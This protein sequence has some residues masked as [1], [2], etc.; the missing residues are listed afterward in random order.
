MV[1]RSGRVARMLEGD[2]I[3]EEEILRAAVFDSEAA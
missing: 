1:L 3:T 2:D